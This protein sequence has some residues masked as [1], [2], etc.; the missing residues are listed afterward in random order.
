L[1]ADSYRHHIGAVRIDKQCADRS[2]HLA[3]AGHQGKTRS[4]VVNVGNSVTRFATY[5]AVRQI[6]NQNYTTQENADALEMG[7]RHRDNKELPSIRIHNLD[8]LAEAHDRPPNRS[9]R[10][11][12]ANTEHHAAWKCFQD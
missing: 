5:L 12:E 3:H 11:R 10:K 9:V 2:R 4:Q 8:P 1:S 6:C 7:L